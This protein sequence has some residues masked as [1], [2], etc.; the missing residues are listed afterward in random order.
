[1]RRKDDS[2]LWLSWNRDSVK[3]PVDNM[4]LGGHPPPRSIIRKVGWR[5]NPWFPKVLKDEM[6]WDK[7]RDM[8]KYLHIWEG[9]PVI[10]SEARVFQNWSMD[11]IDSSVPEDCVPR[12]GADWGFSVDPTVLIECYIFDRVLYFRREAWKVRCE[13]DETPSL[14][15]GTDVHER[16]CWTNLQGHAGLQ[17]ARDGHQIVADSARPETISYMKKRGFNIVRARKGAGSVEDG[18][19]FMKSHDIVV[20]PDCKHVMDELTH[21]SYKEDPLTDEVLPILADAKNHTIDAARYAVE[22]ARRRL[23]G[24]IGLQ[25]PQVV[26]QEED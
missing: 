2:E 24:R 23:R 22:S 15:A 5:D 14:F 18:I 11:D 19:E 25:A 4:F 26:H 12:L 1:M 16:R 8:D 10:R 3:D 20:H 9:E 17:S 21:Y 6:E 7:S 13:I